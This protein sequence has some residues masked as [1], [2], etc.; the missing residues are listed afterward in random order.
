VSLSP[1]ESLQA[2]RLRDQGFNQQAIALA[3]VLC[4]VFQWP[5]AQMANNLISKLREV[6]DRQ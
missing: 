5:E 2:D 3:L 1:N 6:K 4:E